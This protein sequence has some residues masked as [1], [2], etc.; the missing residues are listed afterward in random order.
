[1]RKKALFEHGDQSPNPWNLPLSRWLGWRGRQAAP[2]IQH[3]QRRSG[4]IPGEPYPP[5]RHGQYN[6]GPG[7]PASSIHFFVA[8]NRPGKV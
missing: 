3:R 5:L 8:G 6:A 7:F 2:P 4:S 1:M